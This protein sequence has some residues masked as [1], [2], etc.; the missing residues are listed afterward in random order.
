MPLYEYRCQ[1]CGVF[2][3]WRPIAEV[4]LP[5]YCP[6]CQQ[7]G[8]RL[9]SPPVVLSGS[10]RLKQPRLEPQIVQ[11]D[12]TPKTQRVTTHSGGRPW[13]ISH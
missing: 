3:V 9:F 12:L 1:D 6:T 7:P 8:K 4:Y 11:R 10:L 5:C 13:M 2:D